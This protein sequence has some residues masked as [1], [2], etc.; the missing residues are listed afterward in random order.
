MALRT[1]PKPKRDVPKWERTRAQFAIH[2]RF[3][4]D[5]VSGLE[6]RLAAFEL[7]K[8]EQIAVDSAQALLESVQVLI[9]RNHKD[10]PE[11]TGVLADMIETRDILVK[12]LD[13]IPTGVK[14]R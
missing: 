2:S 13:T 7:A 9:S 11:L 3:H 5:D 4:P 14:V 8:N 10:G 1:T 12:L 6:A